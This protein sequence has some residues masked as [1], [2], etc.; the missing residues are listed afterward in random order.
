[1][2][3]V[4]G[5]PIYG[6]AKSGAGELNVGN[7]RPSWQITACQ[8]SKS[9]NCIAVIAEACRCPELE[10]MDALV[11]AGAALRKA[12]EEREALQAEDEAMLSRKVTAA[13]YMLSWS[14]KALAAASGVGVS[15]IADFER[16]ARQTTE[17]NK[18]KII[19]AI[20]QAGVRI[21][22]F[23]IEK[24]GESVTLKRGEIHR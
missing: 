22:P 15:T 21:I 24:D 16:G 14:Q 20:E 19:L 9:G 4:T 2:V 1:M 8:F 23:G 3:K 10:R 11:R 6:A 17:E 18:R 7:G 13:R 12:R 5:L